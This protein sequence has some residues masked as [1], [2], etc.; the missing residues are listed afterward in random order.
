MSWSSLVDDAMGFVS[1]SYSAAFGD[2]KTSATIGDIVGIV[3]SAVA[4][5]VAAGPVAVFA[6]GAAVGWGTGRAA[7]A[8]GL[9]DKNLEAF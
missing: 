5:G 4:A 3:A 9:T 7:K 6:A 8:L 2:D 1:S